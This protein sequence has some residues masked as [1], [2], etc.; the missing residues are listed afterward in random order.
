MSHASFVTN[1][2]RRDP[3]HEYCTPYLLESILR[4]YCTRE[5]RVPRITPQTVLVRFLCG[6]GTEYSTV[7]IERMLRMLST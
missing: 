4:D 1:T 7:V 3:L 5:V 2:L 6:A